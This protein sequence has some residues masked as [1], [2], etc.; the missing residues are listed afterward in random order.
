MKKKP[1]TFKEM[2]EA[3]QSLIDQHEFNEDKKDSLLIMSCGDEGSDCLIAG[4]SKEIAIALVMTMIKSESV[5]NIVFAAHETYVRH[6]VRNTAPS[7]EP[8]MKGIDKMLKDMK[9]NASAGPRLDVEFK[10]K[11]LS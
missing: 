4:H 9:S 11:K 2:M 5:K 8:L 7:L 1:Q 6:T 3:I 10:P